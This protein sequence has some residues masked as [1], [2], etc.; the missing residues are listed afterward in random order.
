MGIPHRYY[1]NK[2]TR[3]LFDRGIVWVL[4]KQSH[5]RPCIAFAINDGHFRGL[6]YF[7]YF[8]ARNDTAIATK[9]MAKSGALRS[10]EC[11]SRDSG[12]LFG[13]E[14][15]WKLANLG[16]RELAN[17]RISKFEGEIGGKSFSKKV[18]SVFV[19]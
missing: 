18:I 9:R 16:I 17:L 14:T 4:Q 8:L 12:V 19:Y 10:R 1:G 13:N 15:I 11:R 3:L 5:Y 7:L 2:Y 6:Y